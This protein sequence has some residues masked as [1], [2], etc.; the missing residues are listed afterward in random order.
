[1]MLTCIHYERYPEPRVARLHRQRH[2]V[3][4]TGL[5]LEYNGTISTAGALPASSMGAGIFQGT[6]YSSTTHL[7]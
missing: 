4:A 6:Q 3:C 5:Y 7:R 2:I 1:M